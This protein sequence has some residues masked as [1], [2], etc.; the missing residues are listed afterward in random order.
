MRGE[1]SGEEGGC[2]S[3]FGEAHH[4]IDYCAVRGLVFADALLLV[5][6]IETNAMRD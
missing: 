3:V 4:Y 5:L 6:K 2:L 1:S